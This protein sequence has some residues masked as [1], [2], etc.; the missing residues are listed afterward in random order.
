MDARGPGPGVV[1]KGNED[2]VLKPGTVSVVKGEKLG[3][4]MMGSVAQQCDCTY[5]TVKYG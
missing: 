3:E 2:L 5:Y 4:M 1:R